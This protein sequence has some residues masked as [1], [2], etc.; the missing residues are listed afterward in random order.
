[1]RWLVSLIK[2]VIRDA[3]E[4]SCEEF[5]DE[6]ALSALEEMARD[7]E[8]GW[9][10]NGAFAMFTTILSHSEHCISSVG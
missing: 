9:A 5:L 2:A 4:Q 8:Q 7:K 3:I 6:N 1:M 10:S